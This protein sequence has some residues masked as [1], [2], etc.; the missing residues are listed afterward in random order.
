[1]CRRQGGVLA[2]SRVG[3][4]L[5][6]DCLVGDDPDLPAGRRLGHHDRA[7]RAHPRVHGGAI[8]DQATLGREHVVAG[9]YLG[10]EPDPADGRRRV[11]RGTAKAWSAT[12]AVMR[13]LLA[14]LDAVADNLDE[15]DAAAVLRYLHEVARVNRAYRGVD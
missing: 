4:D 15:R 7:G 13:P 3:Q 2:E 8:A 9:G 14:E 12:V 10:R 11:L 5:S 6:A 1:M